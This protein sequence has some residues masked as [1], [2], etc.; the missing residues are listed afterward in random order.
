MTLIYVSGA[1][2]DSTERGRVMWARRFLRG[3]IIYW[4]STSPSAQKFL[5]PVRHSREYSDR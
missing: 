3:L 4:R 1:G 2:I 5:T